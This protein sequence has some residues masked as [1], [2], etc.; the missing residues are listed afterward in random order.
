MSARALWPWLVLLALGAFHGVNPGMGWLFAVALGLQEM[1]RQAVWRALPPLAVGHALAIGVVVL[2]IGTLQVVLAEHRMRWFCAAGLA[3]FGVYRLLRTRHP[4][5]VG[6]R[7]G[8]WDLTVWSFLMASAHGAGLMLV[9]VLLQWPASDSAHVQLLQ[10]L[11][12]PGMALSTAWLCAA[13]AVHT[14]GMFVVTAAVAILVY[15]KLGLQL[16]RQSWFNL[17]RL[18]AGALLIASAFLVLSA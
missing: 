1:R 12:P 16:L 3:G 8:F 13:V 11:I 4:R 18:W 2:L 17:D 15:E 10:R 6:M 5:W 7:V 14:L 9:P